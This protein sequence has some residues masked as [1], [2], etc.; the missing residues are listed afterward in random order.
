MVHGLGACR[1]DME[2]IKVELRRYYDKRI[3]VYISTSNEGRTEG[4]IENMGMRL[5]T[6]V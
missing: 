2:K 1:L 5:A 3:R 4:D 6:E